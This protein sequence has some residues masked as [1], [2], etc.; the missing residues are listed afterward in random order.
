MGIARGPAPPTIE[1][2]TND[3]NMTKSLLFF[4]FQFLLAFFAYN[5]GYGRLQQ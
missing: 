3:K 2:A 1:I 4:Q 5:Q